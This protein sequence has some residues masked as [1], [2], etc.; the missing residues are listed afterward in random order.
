[1]RDQVWQWIYQSPPLICA[2]VAVDAEGH[3]QGFLHYRTFVRPLAATMGGYV[4]DLF[5]V[6]EVRG[7][8]VARR[9]IKA[10]AAIGQVNQWSVV[11]WMTA[12]DNQRARTCYDKIAEHTHWQ[13]YQMPL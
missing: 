3:L 8:G 10:V 6:P 5:V 9:L 12:K 13:T 11:R 2:L 1:M 7:Q 4:D